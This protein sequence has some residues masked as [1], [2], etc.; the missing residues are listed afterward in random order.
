MTTQLIATIVKWAFS[1]AINQCLMYTFK[2][3]NLS[4][5]NINKE[6]AVE[7]RG[8]TNRFGTQGKIKI[9]FEVLNQ[10]NY[11]S[12]SWRTLYKA[13]WIRLKQK[14]DEWEENSWKRGQK[15]WPA[16]VKW[17]ERARMEG[18]GADGGSQPRGCSWETVRVRMFNTI[19][20][21]EVRKN[22]RS[23][24]VFYRANE[25]LTMSSTTSVTSWWY[26]TA[27]LHQCERSSCCMH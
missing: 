13:G 27:D 22:S 17:V 3:L 6:T 20:V 25:Q 19:R 15:V 9:R 14:G 26:I 24:N 21:H 1:S 18:V 7:V 12:T 2:S 11:I 10:R 4:C 8:F 5:S 23:F 16:T